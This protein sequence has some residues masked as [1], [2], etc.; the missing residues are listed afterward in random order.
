[1][2][3]PL[4]SIVMILAAIAAVVLRIIRL[5]SD[6]YPHLS[7]S[8]A[9]L[10]DEGFYIHN[11]RNVVLFG[12][13]KT[14]G[15]NNMLIM[16]TLHFVQVWVFR[17]FGVGAIQARS[18]SAVCGM[19]ETAILT[20][21]LWKLF[22]KRAGLAAGLFVGLGHTSL[23]YSRMALMDTPAA[24]F[25]TVQFSLWAAAVRRASE[26]K[27]PSPMAVT[28]GVVAGLCYVTRGLAVWC[29]LL[30]W[31]ALP[32]AL[33][34]L[35]QQRKLCWLTAAAHSAGFV[36][37]FTVYLLTWYLPNHE[38]I[39]AMNRYYMVHQLLPHS[40]VALKGNLSHAFIGDFRGLFPYLFRHSTV[41]W[42]L[43]TTLAA[44]SAA[45]AL[46]ARS[47]GGESV[48]LMHGAEPVQRIAVT[49]LGWWLLLPSM[50]YAVISYA[51]DR[52]YVLFYPAMAALAG[53]VLGL[54]KPAAEALESSWALT[55][56]AGLLA[57]HAVEALVHHHADL[58]LAALTVAAVWVFRPRS[59][60]VPKLLRA[61]V[62]AAAPLAAMV[63]WGISEACWTAD[64]LLHP[65][66]TQRDACQKLANMLPSDAVLLGDVGPGL[67][68]DSK[69]RAESVIPGLCNDDSP[70]EIAAQH[71]VYITI[72]DGRFLE[73]YWTDYCPEQLTQQ[74]RVAYFPALL[75]KY[76][77][78]VY[79]VGRDTTVLPPQ[80]AAERP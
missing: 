56:I 25:L 74:H 68:L 14:D 9:L 22:G 61:E 73:H 80:P 62:L 58:V 37:V 2:G 79:R 59:P 11:A 40:L 5:Q 1:V 6:A 63:L 72:L 44:A 12:T 30:P 55:V 35:P 60:L 71:P 67:S 41:P 39:A 23:L 54:L 42:V 38:E 10:T 4:K 18:I 31:A 33:R 27:N 13:A 43:V 47:A 70:L 32:V 48:G 29:V 17:M 3:H 52:Y 19:L 15:F 49:Y 75:G 51:P 16:P 50:A 28:A 36:A 69:F 7:W 78:G 46:K 24:L 20:A 76:P 8:S 65:A 21:T 66:Y 57:Y 26:G 34:T 45:A 53:I 64:W 77:V